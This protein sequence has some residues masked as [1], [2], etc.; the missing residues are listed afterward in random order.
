M[1]KKDLLVLEHMRESA[2]KRCK[3]PNANNGRAF[4]SCIVL[5]NNYNPISHIGINK[6][7]MTMTHGTIHAEVDALIKLPCKKK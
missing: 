6:Y 5:D 1:N 4:M 3:I 7:E 2:K